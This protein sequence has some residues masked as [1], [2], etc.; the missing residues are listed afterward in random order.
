MKQL[1]YDQLK[2]HLV[3]L[4]LMLAILSSRKDVLV[5]FSDCNAYCLLWA[6]CIPVV[7]ALRVFRNLCDICCIHIP[8]GSYNMVWCYNC[9]YFDSAVLIVCPSYDFKG[10]LQR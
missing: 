5:T 4:D 6:H 8:W 3:L 1:K 9:G 10:P 7:L 2:I